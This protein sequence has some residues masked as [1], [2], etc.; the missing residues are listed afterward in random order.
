MMC[1]V[2]KKD[3]S[4]L[5]VIVLTMKTDGGR[6]GSRCDNRTYQMREMNNSMSP[7]QQRCLLNDDRIQ[8]RN[9]IDRNR[10]DEDAGCLVVRGSMEIHG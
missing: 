9:G 7:L 3:E 5:V 4:Q 1:S 6:E 10:D 8:I 2:E